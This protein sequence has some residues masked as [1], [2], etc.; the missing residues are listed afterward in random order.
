MRVGW[1]RVVCFERAVRDSD[2]MTPVHTDAM[3]NCE[4]QHSKQQLHLAKV[5]GDGHSLCPSG[6][7]PRA[8]DAGRPEA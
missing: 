3:A 7:A 6:H 1:E 2:S 8:L 5:G 4:A